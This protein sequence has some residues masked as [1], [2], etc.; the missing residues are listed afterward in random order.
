MGHQLGIK[1]TPG[2]QFF[3]SARLDHTALVERHDLVGP[4]HSREPMRNHQCGALSHQLLQRLAHCLLVN[5]VE[6]RCGLVQNQHRGI[7]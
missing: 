6:V 4:A 5:R 7:L 1:T 3:V 2:Q